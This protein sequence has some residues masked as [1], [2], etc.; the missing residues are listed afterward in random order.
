VA[1][2]PGDL[3]L[4]VGGAVATGLG[5]SPLFAGVPGLVGSTLA[6]LVGGGLAVWLV[7]V[8]GNDC[9]TRRTD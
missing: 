7:R 1:G 5:F 9:V 4:G 6:A 3:G 2:P 8:A